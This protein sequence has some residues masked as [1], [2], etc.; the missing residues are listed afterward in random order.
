MA[1]MT[2]EEKLALYWQSLPIGRENAVSYDGLRVMWNTSKRG[3]RAILHDL[4]VQD[5]GDNY[6]LI[7]SS[8]GV[9]FYK[10]DDA[11]EIKAYRKECM[12]RGAQILLATLKCDRVLYGGGGE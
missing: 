2:Y 9:G 1:K 3:A 11:L 6:V 12:S 5:N 10:T 4:A 8:H 7:R